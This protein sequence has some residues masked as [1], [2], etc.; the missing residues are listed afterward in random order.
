LS[1]TTC[2]TKMAMIMVKLWNFVQFQICWFAL[3]LSA[4]NVMPWLGVA[5]TGALLACHLRWFAKSRE[6]LLLLAVG[7]LGW[8]WESL[9]QV[10][11]LMIYSSEQQSLSLAPLW[12]AMLWLNFAA[13]LNHSMAW[14]KGQWFYSL[15]LGASGAPLA[16]W[17]GVK[18]GAASFGDELVALIVISLGWALILPLIVH[19]AVIINGDNKPVLSFAE[20]KG[21][22]HV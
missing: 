21:D 8:F 12:I 7:L 15:L 3:V 6:W 1:A 10:S 5:I 16:F 22:T 11:G 13:T 9:L 19:W 17:A 2:F 20:N 18:L 4:A 14:L